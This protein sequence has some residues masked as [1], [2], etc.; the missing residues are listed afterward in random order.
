[1]KQLSL[2]P[3]Q[4]EQVLSHNDLL[5]LLAEMTDGVFRYY[6]P[7]FIELELHKDAQAVRPVK[8]RDTDLLIHCSGGWDPSVQLDEIA[9]VVVN[10]E[11]LKAWATGLLLGDT[12]W[13]TRGVLGW[14][15]ALPTFLSV[16]SLLP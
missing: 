7:A 6:S 9:F 4:R 10:M 8:Q 1:M 15:P 11:A 5:R 16:P 14:V 13:A 12:G 2:F 3:S